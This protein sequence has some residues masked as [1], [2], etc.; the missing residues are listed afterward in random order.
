[1]DS[2]ENQK[3]PYCIR[4]RI[5]INKNDQCFLKPGY[6]ELLHAI[7]TEGS[8]NTAAKNIGISYQ[9][10]WKIIEQMNQLSPLPVVIPKRGGKDGGGAEL[11]SYGLR[12]INEMNQ[13]E[14]AFAD[15]LLNANKHF[16][17][18]FDFAQHP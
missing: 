4:G 18:C 8:I 14:M 10:A 13:L 11:T 7:H 6:V 3:N 17:I 12:V 15:F 2:Q 9:Y 1:M 5:W 16:E